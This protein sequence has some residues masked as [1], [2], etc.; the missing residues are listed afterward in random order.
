ML[1]SPTV[2]QIA[3]VTNGEIL[4]GN[5]QTE[6]RS[7]STDTRTL[8]AG[9]L[10]I[11]LVGERF[12]GHEFVSQATD[13]GAVAVLTERPLDTE[14]AQIKVD[15]TLRALADLAAWHRDQFSGRVVAVTGSAG[16][17]T[18]KQLMGSVLAQR[19]ETLITKGNLNNHIGAPLTLLSIEPEHQAAM[20]ELGASGVGEIAYTAE[21]TRPEVGILTNV[22]PAHLE[23]FGSIENIAQ[24]KGELID[25]VQADGAV[26][27]NAD[28]RFFSDWVSRAGSK[29]VISF[30]LHQPSDVYATDIRE[31]LEGSA[32]TLH[33]PAGSVSLFLSL[34]GVHN[35]RNALSVAAASTHL[36]FSL[37]EIKAGLEQATAFSGRL[38]VCD[39]VNGQTI[40][41]DAYNA[42]PESF[43]A[44][45]DVLALA[46]GNKILVMGDMGELGKSAAAMHERV[47]RYAHDKG[48]QTLVATGPLSKHATDVFG[49][50][51][52]WFET[53]EAVADYVKTTTEAGDTVL[54]KGSRSAGMDQVV[55]SLTEEG[56]K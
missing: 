54:V 56:E 27:L 6:C 51:A 24:T 12:D 45:I 18:V 30:G 8:T 7:V 46:Q 48:I 4:S 35:V 55:R 49:D 1:L 21:L 42:N 5:P 39:G 36:G 2:E 3:E 38:E 11:P 13:A 14:I 52:Y 44:A 37:A 29:K 16:K 19:Y 43:C 25:S 31:S 32:F 40:F 41:N 15:D 28:D 23:G 17:T 22:V 26:I 9:S 33:T 10:Y 47:G 50:N 20:I 34:A 53:R